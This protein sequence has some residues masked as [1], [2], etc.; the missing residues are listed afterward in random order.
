MPI[1]VNAEIFDFAVINS[2]T[3][4]SLPVV[5]SAIEE[6][7]AICPSRAVTQSKWTEVMCSGKLSLSEAQSF[8]SVFSAARESV[9]GQFGDWINIQT[10]GLLMICQCFPNTRVRADSFH[11]SEILA[12]SLTTAAIS[13]SH[14][15]SSVGLG[16][17]PGRSHLLNISNLLRDN[18]SIQQFVSDCIPLIVGMISLELVA[19]GDFTVG[20]DEVNKL[21][22][23]FLP[24]HGHDLAEQLMGGLTTISSSELI[25]RLS[26]MI[27]WNAELFP[28]YDLNSGPDSSR[29]DTGEIGMIHIVNQTKCSLVLTETA[30]PTASNIYVV[31]CSDVSIFVA[32]HTRNVSIFGCTDVEIVLMAVTGSVVVNF[33]DRVTLRCVAS[34]V[35]LD[36]AIDCRTFVYSTRSTILTGDTRGVELA[37]FNVLYSRH[38]GLLEGKSVLVTHASHATLWSQPICA[39][40]TETPYVLLSPAKFALVRFPEFVPHNENSLAVCLPE[41]HAEALERKRRL[42]EELRSQL[43]S[44]PD[45]SSA[46]K[47]NSVLSGHFREWIS[48]NNKLRPIVDI[49]R[50]YRQT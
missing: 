36:N 44:L 37:P 1:Y 50:S 26:T 21:R 14:T 6:L 16:R 20:I 3:K 13:P 41:V 32:E 4:L 43:K 42:I 45:E 30:S 47:V 49:I 35:R 12:Q 2:S 9:L 38:Q 48:A 5:S 29:K 19:D 17:S 27:S 18:A 34:H 28:Q 22:I 46:Q 31:N 24:Q 8:W 25:S 11:R 7:K 33:S 40:L 10:L 23:L 15:N 39:T